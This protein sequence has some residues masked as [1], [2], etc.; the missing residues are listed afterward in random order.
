MVGEQ[1]SEGTNSLLLEGAHPVTSAFDLLNGYAQLYPDR[2]FVERIPVYRP[3]IRLT[4]VKGAAK[5]RE[6][7]V[8]VEP[9]AKKT[10]LQ[11]AAEE[12]AKPSPR[13]R[14]EERRDE[15][16]ADDPPFRGQPSGLNE[17]ESAVY[18]ALSSAAEPLSTDQIVTC[19]GLSTSDVMSAL[20]MMEIGG[21]VTSLPG[22]RFVL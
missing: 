6:E 13:K 5:V 19:T 3:Q 8:R 12:N 20:T 7:V 21:V 10:V 15:R 9:P 18:R 16:K 11:R 22:G 14:E 17:Q 4:G 1:N 2:I